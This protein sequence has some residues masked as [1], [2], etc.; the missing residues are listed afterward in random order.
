MN[1]LILTK[2]A[3]KKII[4]LVSD[5]NN[6][7]ML[8]VS[9]TGGGCQGFQYNLDMDS[10][11]KDNDIIIQEK[12]AIVII[13]KNSLNLLKGSELDFVDDLTG[14]RFKINNPK[15]T[16]ACGCGTSFSLK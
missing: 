10:K 6:N 4:E 7:N 16:S 8:R 14:S 11:K 15:A 1:Q 2:N 13:D 5:K 12:S 3:I 9:V